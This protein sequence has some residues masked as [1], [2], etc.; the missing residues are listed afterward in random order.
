MRHA[1]PPIKAGGCWPRASKWRLKRRWTGRPCT[2]PRRLPS[3]CRRRRRDPPKYRRRN[4][5]RHR[6]PPRRR[7]KR[8][9]I[10]DG[11]G[12]LT[13]LLRL[14]LT[15]STSVVAIRFGQNGNFLPIERESNKWPRPHAKSRHAPSARARRGARD[16]PHRAASRWR[17]GRGRARLRRAS[18]QHS[19][20]DS[21]GVVR[22]EAPLRSLRPKFFDAFRLFGTRKKDIPA[23]NVRRRDV[24]VRVLCS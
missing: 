21:A 6:C 15:L 16:I 9:A 24:T 12:G 23:T 14:A 2:P 1:C 19:R 3:P 17:G 22:P 11:S 10:T 13:R 4:Q 18:G 5:R 20:S 8:G 7:N